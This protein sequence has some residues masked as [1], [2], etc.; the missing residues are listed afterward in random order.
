MSKNIPSSHGNSKEITIYVNGITDEKI[1]ARIDKKASLSY[2]ISMPRTLIYSQ[3]AK[4]TLCAVETVLSIRSVQYDAKTTK[5]NCILNVPQNRVL[6]C[7]SGLY[8]YG[9]LFVSL[10]F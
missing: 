2:K 3:Y 5:Y 4:A 1:I 10:P 9:I 7:F 8:C 6:Y